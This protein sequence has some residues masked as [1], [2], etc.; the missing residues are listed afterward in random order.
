M[1]WLDMA[2]DAGLRGQEARDYAQMYMDSQRSYEGQ[3]ASEE[4][5]YHGDE[6]DQAYADAAPVEQRAEIMERGGRC[7]CGLER[8][9]IGGPKPVEEE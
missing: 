7:Y 8:Y 3:C 1:P 9:P 2:H 6:F 5:P 4:H